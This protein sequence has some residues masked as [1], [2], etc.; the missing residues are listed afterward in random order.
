MFG[1]NAAR[2]GDLVEILS[3]IIVEK[4]KRVKS[5]KIS[6]KKMSSASSDWILYNVYF[7]LNQRFDF[8]TFNECLLNHNDIRYDGMDFMVTNNRNSQVYGYWFYVRSN[9]LDDFYDFIHQEY[10]ESLIGDIVVDYDNK[11]LRRSSGRTNYKAGQY[12]V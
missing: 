9:L 2:A 11:I 12:R 4:K 8:D 10:R 3:F 6:K 1:I 7:E 5:G